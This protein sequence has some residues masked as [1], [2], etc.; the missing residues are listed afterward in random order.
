MRDKKIFGEDVDSFRPERFLEENGKLN[1]LEEYIQMSWGVGRRYCASLYEK[2]ML[3]FINLVSILLG[4][5]FICFVSYRS[6]LGDKL[7]Q[8]SIF[9][10]L[11][12]LLRNFSFNKVPGLPEPTMEPIFGMIL[13][14]QPYDI[15]VRERC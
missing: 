12:Y 6:C 7:A 14:P 3:L 10:F 8:S 15:V 4:C 13:A 9:M 11:T 1:G 5:V 2:I